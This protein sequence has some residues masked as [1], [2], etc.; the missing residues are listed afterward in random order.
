MKVWHFDFNNQTISV[1]AASRNDAY[2]LL[3]DY[4]Q[5]LDQ[6]D[7][8]D[9]VNDTEVYRLFDRLDQDPIAVDRTR[10]LVNHWRSVASQFVADSP[11]NLLVKSL[12]YDIADQLCLVLNNP[13]MKK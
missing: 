10:A 7:V 9:M 2:R 6:C 11:E 4:V 13:Q 5:P 12:F 3:K 8:S 1:V